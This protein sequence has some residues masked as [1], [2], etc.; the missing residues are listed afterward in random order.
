MKEFLIN[1]SLKA[2]EAQQ[3][4]IDHTT[5][6]LLIIAGPGTGKTHTLVNRIL[7]IK[8]NLKRQE[9]ILAI[10]FSNKASCQMDSR[11]RAAWPEFDDTIFVG[12][13]HSFSL[14]LLKEFFDQTELPKDFK[15]ASPDEIEEIVSDLWPSMKKKERKNV[16]REISIW[17]STK[18]PAQTH[19]AVCE[20][21]YFLRERGLIDFDDLLLEAENLLNKN[22]S[23]KDK[24][25]DLYPYIFV[26]EYQDINAIQN[27]FLK[28][29]VG[30]DCHIT[31]IGDPNQAI[32]SFRG[33]NVEFFE[34]FCQ[35]FKNAEILSLSENY[36]STAFILEASRQV[37]SLSPFK[38]PA[39]SANIYKEGKLNI[40]DAPSERAEAEYVVEKI[41]KL[42]GGISH[43]SLDSNRVNGG[44]DPLVSF[45]DIVILY[46]LKM[47]RN[48][49]E[50]ALARSGMPF[51][52]SGDHPHYTLDEY[53]FQAEKINLM[54]MHAA[55][56][57]EFP[58]VFIVGCEE[59]LLP[60]QLDGL[61]ADIE[62]ERRLFYV[63]MTRAKERLY[64]SRSKVRMIFGKVYK[65]KP[66]RYLEDI[67][68]NL[69]EFYEAEKRMKVRRKEKQVEFF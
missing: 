33:S 11:L 5:S 47:Q 37:I 25:N 12:T 4:A 17:K 14:R 51:Q 44:E 41:E 26:D 2:N 46:R 31:A 39:L 3:K 54:T 1:N 27:S 38:V 34:N 67:D 9:K 65:N 15:V 18:A 64:F 19:D 61:D 63:A 58:V 7:K 35:D 57:L 68:R 21:D 28:L 56:G 36:R 62:E 49:L 40:Y 29:L 55:K 10:T 22:K 6:H 59:R 30:D 43:F 23:I 66:S 24:I 60:L 69:K 50:C 8:E 48:A 42:M 53:D 45:G 52:V 32:Y 16:L 13:F 20:Y